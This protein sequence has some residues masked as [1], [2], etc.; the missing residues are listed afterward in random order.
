MKLK[1]IS[2]V[3]EAKLRRQLLPVLDELGVTDRQWLLEILPLLGAD[4]K[5][6]LSECLKTAFPGKAQAG[7]MKGFKVFRGAVNKAA[8]TANVP[9]SFAVDTS[10]KTPPSG[11]QCWFEAADTTE[12]EIT[13][14][15]EQG[16][17]DVDPQAVQNTGLLTDWRKLLAGPTP[18]RIQKHFFASL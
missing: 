2:F 7:A 15:S 9:L 14:F 8:D 11:R 13:Q 3:S 6:R 12:Q 18:V 16:T 17:R 4:G 10:K 1:R 5:A